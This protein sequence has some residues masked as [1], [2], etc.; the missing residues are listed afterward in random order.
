MPYT[1][2]LQNAPFGYERTGDYEVAMRDVLEAELGGEVGVEEALKLY[3]SPAQPGSPLDQAE[4]LAWDTAFAGIADWDSDAQAEY[5]ESTTLHLQLVST[6]FKLAWIA[7]CY[8][9]LYRLGAKLS[10]TGNIAAFSRE[11]FMRRGYLD[12]VEVARAEWDSWPLDQP[13]GNDGVILHP[14]RR[15]LD[16]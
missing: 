16:S 3:G 13:G 4:T 11:M 2:Q 6:E 1:L 15:R 7:A 10:N 5:L 14:L 12:P 8:T 9:E